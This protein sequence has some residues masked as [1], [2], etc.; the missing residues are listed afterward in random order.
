MSALL[1][2]ATD[3]RTSQKVN[4]GAALVGKAFQASVSDLPF[5]TPPTLRRKPSHGGLHRRSWECDQIGAPVL[6]WGQRRPRRETSFSM[7]RMTSPTVDRKLVPSGVKPRAAA[8]SGAQPADGKAQQRTHGSQ[9]TSQARL[10]P[11]K[12]LPP[13]LSRPGLTCRLQPTAALSPARG[14]SR[15]AGGPRASTAEAARPGPAPAHKAVGT[16]FRPSSESGRSSPKVTLAFCQRTAAEERNTRRR[17]GR[18]DSSAS[19]GLL[20]REAGCSSGGR[21]YPSQHSPGGGDAGGAVGRDTASPPSRKPQGHQAPGRGGLWIAG[22]SCLRAG[23]TQS[24]LTL[25]KGRPAKEV[26]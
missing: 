10:T 11:G 25:W 3:S 24:V 21:P 6:Q 9:G 19:R 4:T 12:A 13:T 1:L 26:F 7:G 5:P 18:T 16:L 14:T 20:T 15:P 22:P 8:A 23:P 17:A 2:L